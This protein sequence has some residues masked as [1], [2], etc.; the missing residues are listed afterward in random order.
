MAK[1]NN[2]TRAMEIYNMHIAL[3]ST[4]GR[5][6]RKTVREQYIS[7]LNCSEAAASTIY[8]NCKKA[9]PAIEGLG[10]APLPA[11]IRRPGTSNSEINVEYQDDNECY[12]V[13]EITNGHVCRCESFLYQ[14]EASEVFDT[15]IDLWPTSTWVLIKGLGPNSGDMFK[16]ENGEAEIKRYD[17]AVVTSERLAASKETETV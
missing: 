12:S 10:R 7:E 8:N 11:G 2:Q 4:D 14:G 5:L 16:L 6:F 17:F 1:Q 15:K 9:S 13:M 3:A